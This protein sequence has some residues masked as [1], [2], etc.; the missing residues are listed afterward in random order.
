MFNIWLVLSAVYSLLRCI[1]ILN[2]NNGKQYTF[3]R[4][5]LLFV[6]VS[7]LF[8]F[9]LYRVLNVVRFSGLSLQYSPTF[10]MT[11]DIPRLTWHAIKTEVQFDCCLLRLPRW[12]VIGIINLWKSSPHYMAYIPFSTWW[13]KSSLVTLNIYR[14]ISI[15][16]KWLDCVWLSSLQLF[17]LTVV[18]CQLS[19]I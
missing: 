5:L 9:V 7:M 2:T 6:C 18:Q 3:T 19:S 14:L 17:W 12:Y 10:I 8:V 1:L 4:K 15:L 16:L 13:S 11:F